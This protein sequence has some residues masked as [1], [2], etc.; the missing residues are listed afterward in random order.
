MSLGHRLLVEEKSQKYEQ[1]N[2]EIRKN[3]NS[4]NNN[5]MNKQMIGKRQLWT[6]NVIQN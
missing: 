6:A 5:E 4:K 1:A 3:C 2:V